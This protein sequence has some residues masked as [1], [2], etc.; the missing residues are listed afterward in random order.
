M[1][2]PVIRTEAQGDIGY[3]ILNRPQVR[4]SL[5]LEAYGA[6]PE[7][8]A[9]LQ[10]SGVKV[11][12]VRGAGEKAFGAGSDI[13]EFPALRFGREAAVNYN[14]IEEDALVAIVEV[15]MPTIAMVHGFCVGG[16]LEVAVACD[17]RV[18]ARGAR[19]GATPA[20]LGVAFSRQNIERLCH[21]LGPAHTKELLFTAELIDAER[22]LGIGLVNRVVDD[23]ALEEE[24]LA[25]AIS[26][27]ANAP[28]SLS[29]MKRA[30]NDW[31][32]V[33][34][35]PD[36]EGGGISLICYESEDYREGVEAFIEKRK[37]EFRGR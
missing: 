1:D 33:E 15:S 35:V 9:T 7:A 32:A 18:A 12:V 30:V 16:G 31:A 36:N 11:I 25:L 26:I 5:N 28:L 6:I 27:A 14:R 17:L 37:P 29:E 8:V 22:A 3:L 23:E 19:F 24:T 2:E 20:K 10:G 4:N 21:L 34:D 13:S